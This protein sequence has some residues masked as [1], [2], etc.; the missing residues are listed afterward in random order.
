MFNHIEVIMSLNYY[1]AMIP[2]VF[3]GFGIVLCTITSFEFII[4]QSPIVAKL[5]GYNLFHSFLL[6]LAAVPIS[7]FCYYLI[8][9]LLT[10]HYLTHSV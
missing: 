9:T 8:R 3:G 7:G 10:L 1:W 2:Q 5:N 4:A 6:I